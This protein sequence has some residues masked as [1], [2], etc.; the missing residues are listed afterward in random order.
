MT[1]RVVVASS[2]P[3]RE[4][5]GMFDKTAIKVNSQIGMHAR[6]ASNKESLAATTACAPDP[7]THTAEVLSTA[8]LPLAHIHT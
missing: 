1:E 6:T 4:R 7:N 8:L 5:K 2:D 3:T